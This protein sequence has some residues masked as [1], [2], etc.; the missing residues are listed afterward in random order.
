MWVNIMRVVLPSWSV[1]NGIPQAANVR[2][3]SCATVQD[4][5]LYLPESIHQSRL[6]RTH[7][8]NIIVNG[9][10]T[11]HQSSFF[12]TGRYNNFVK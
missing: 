10:N 12:Y 5:V 4:R 7:P 1:V 6:R 9:N 2:G 11:H 3:Q 8:Q